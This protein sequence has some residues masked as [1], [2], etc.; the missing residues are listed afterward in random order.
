MN[1]DCGPAWLCHFALS[2]PAWPRCPKSRHPT[3]SSTPSA[4]DRKRAPATAR[5]CG[6]ARSS[7]DWAGDVD[8]RAARHDGG[9]QRTPDRRAEYE[10]LQVLRASHRRVTG[11]AGSSGDR[12][13]TRL[14]SSHS[15]ISYAVF[16]LKKK[17]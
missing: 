8:E 16:C 4:P 11:C 13:S 17:N 3:H 14:N 12:K 6:V 9:G 2:S 1:E 15:S 10:L 5:L 7:A